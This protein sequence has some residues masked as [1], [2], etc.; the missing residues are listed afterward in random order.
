MRKDLLGHP[1][2]E[3][4]PYLSRTLRKFD[5][6][7]FPS[8]LERLQH[9]QTIFPKGYWFGLPLESAYIM[10]EVKMT[11]VN[12][13]YIATVML[14][15]AFIEHILQIEVERLGHPVVARKGL[16]EIIKWF[17]RERPHNDFL[18]NRVD[19]L[20]RFRNPFSHLRPFDDPDTLARRA[21]KSQS[22]PSEIIKMETKEA[23]ALMYQV[24]I[25][26]F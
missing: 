26:R 13:N 5:R 8:R 6:D 25:T 18:M 12:G 22:D 11:F 16:R 15:Q 9:L 10:D 19:R 23:L 17:K 4:T 2:K 24:A 14:S 20:R 7:T 1:L 21:M 3:R